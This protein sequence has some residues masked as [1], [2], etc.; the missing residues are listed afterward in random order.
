VDPEIAGFLSSV[1]RRTF[2]AGDVVIENTYL[3]R[4]ATDRTAKVGYVYSG[5]VSGAWH[6]PAIAPSHSV[7]TLV[8]GDGS[9]I[10]MDAFKYRENLFR[11][12]ALVPT[13][14]VILPLAD[15]VSE[16]PRAVLRNALE[17]TANAWCT[18]A[19]VISM[20]RQQLERRAMLLLYN[21]RRIHPRP[22]LEVTQKVVAELLGVSRQTLNPV[23]RRLEERGLVRLGYGRIFVQEHA[24]IIEELRRTPAGVERHE[25]D[26]SLWEM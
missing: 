4:G 10:G 15:L 6:R 26:E 19:S 12:V 17:N 16:A 5:L 1:P 23:L 22:D 2:T 14:A 20:R 11:Y 18:A 7:T 9:W 13:T 24:R 21:L 8:A 25:G 3:Q